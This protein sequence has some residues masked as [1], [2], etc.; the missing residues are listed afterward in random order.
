MLVTSCW[1]SCTESYQTTFFQNNVPQV[2]W[3]YNYPFLENPTGLEKILSAS[4][5]YFRVLYSFLHVLPNNC[6]G[7]CYERS[8]SEGQIKYSF[9]AL[10]CRMVYSHAVVLRNHSPSWKGVNTTFLYEELKVYFSSTERDHSSTV[11]GYSYQI[12]SFDWWL[13]TVLCHMY[14]CVTTTDVSMFCNL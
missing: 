8:T 13:L 5:I 14:S 4:N 1:F 10:Y 7:H 11:Q 6:C 2:E 12:L 3:V 9:Q